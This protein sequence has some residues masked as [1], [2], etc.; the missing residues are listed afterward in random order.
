MSDIKRIWD[1]MLKFIG[2]P[3]GTVGP[4]QMKSF[5]W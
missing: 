5:I 1:T 4:M 2:N 3:Y